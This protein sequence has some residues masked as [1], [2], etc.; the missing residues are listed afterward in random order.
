MPDLLEPTRHDTPS[1]L[2]GKP[3][4]E[5]A[6]R[7]RG[8]QLHG[9]V[10]RVRSLKCTIGSGPDCTVR[11]VAPNVRPLHCLILRGEA[12]AVVRRWSPE[13]FLNGRAFSDAL[14]CAGDRL[15]VGP[16]ELEIVDDAIEEAPSDGRKR[17]HDGAPSQAY[18][19]AAP[20]ANL[21][22]Q[23]AQVLRHDWSRQS[24]ARQQ[25]LMRAKLRSAKKRIKQLRKSAAEANELVRQQ[26]SRLEES[27]AAAELA[28][29]A[30]R[31]RSAGECLALET[32]LR[33]QEQFRDQIE[34][35]LQE[36]TREQ[37]SL[38]ARLT[39]QTEQVRA[40]S[41]EI[42]RARQTLSANEELLEAGSRRLS[43][44][45][46][47]IDALEN[48]KTRFQRIA[49]EYQV[50]E[51]RAGEEVKRLTTRLQE[52]ER[53]I[54]NHAAAAEREQVSSS[55]KSVE[56]QNAQHQV[57]ELAQVVRNRDEDLQRAKIDLARS[58]DDLKAAQ[59]AQATA[60]QERE[61]IIEQ[62]AELRAQQQ[63]AQRAAEAHVA[64]LNERMTA[65]VQVAE[66][67][68]ASEAK[69]QELT[70]ELA[71]KASEY[72]LLIAER[73]Q[74]R[75]QIAEA[76]ANPVESI[77]VP[78][79]VTAYE[80]SVR[81]AAA[82][83]ERL[84]GELAAREQAWEQCAQKHQKRIEQLEKLSNNLE[85]ELRR[86]S[87]EATLSSTEEIHKA[88][89]QAACADEQVTA[90][91]E[92]LSALLAEVDESRERTRHF[93]TECSEVRQQL[94]ERD[95]LMNQLRDEVRAKFA[96]WET[97]RQTLETQLASAHREA[98]VPVAPP[99]SVE[100]H[101][102]TIDRLQTTGDDSA[103]TMDQNRLDE[104]HG[105]LSEPETWREAEESMTREAESADVFDANLHELDLPEI[106]ALASD[107]RTTDD[108]ESA[109]SSEAEPDAATGPSWRDQVA[110]LYNEENEP[111]PP[112]PLVR[113]ITPVASSHS[114]FANG[115]P[116]TESGDEESIEAYMARLL[117]RVRGDASGEVAPMQSVKPVAEPVASPI[118][119]HA[120]P[121]AV[122][123]S[124]IDNTP[125]TPVEFAP[126]S[127]APEH[128]LG[129]A[130]MRELAMHSARQAIDQSALRRFRQ[131]AMLRT[132][133]A[134]LSFGVGTFL[135]CWARSTQN[136]LAIGG[137]M[138]FFVVGGTFAYYR[139]RMM[140]LP[141]RLRAKVL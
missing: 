63:D 124:P 30:D 76:L 127:A 113:P 102:A 109:D 61:D 94:R 40:K 137:A 46:A 107:R 24:G 74:L 119:A 28:R 3:E 73:D 110:Y 133:G 7:I 41:D 81:E 85:A 128:Q 68:Q 135:V 83:T 39:E 121:A 52:M 100:I 77:P 14:L 87:D 18:D 29:A 64:A 97:E 62:L 5:L 8:G 111:T 23:I 108:D 15:Q 19:T 104:V 86:S 69:C 6:L 70:S 79:D 32:K 118:Q 82:E 141:S 115:S 53:L 47:K 67:L 44:A 58:F 103:E 31:E 139:L 101:S 1:Q 42:E 88:K 48:E 66:Q 96:E 114:S 33:E 93:E 54:T 98:Q 80:N 57:E 120:A 112:E 49:S 72:E 45:Q 138:V 16:I 26:I 84:R 122:T 65:A 71:T 106:D 140:K 56:L 123:E 10:V 60:E 125:L 132:L 89:Q 75:Q 34:A 55:E 91:Q 37:E 131:G 51:S 126:R 20:T 99:D 92:Q 4:G 78:V 50:V 130:A 59:F 27:L 117:K 2:L 43:E 136:N 22:D 36:V 13:T 9:R 38:T 134:A 21:A 90:L 129:M 25:K 116:V 17:R 11:L 12:G 95:E 105:V 35:R